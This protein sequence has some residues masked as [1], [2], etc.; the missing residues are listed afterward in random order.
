M[1]SYP[2]FKR[3]HGFT[4]IELIVVI[5]ILATLMGI[6]YPAIM[7]Y[8]ESANKAAADKIGKDI[9]GA[10]HQFRQDHNGILPFDPQ[11]A[12][13]NREDQIFLNT[14]RGKDAH[15]VSIITGYEEG[16]EKFN[17]NNQAYM[18]PAK[19]EDRSNGLYGDS[20]SELGL[21]DPW[22]SPY[23]IVLCESDDGC[24]DPFTGKRY[25]GECCMVYSTG[26]DRAGI[27]PAHQGRK[28]KGKKSAALVEEEEDLIQDN[29]YSWKKITKK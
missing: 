28:K 1:K 11:M 4:L 18:N 19:V 21:Y 8:R 25:R 22:G 29:V 7:S 20:Q 10:V 3:F 23:Y 24:I 5:A 15:L 26:P 27:A 12:K 6:A 17:I 13:P 9:V 14:D 2:T 16:D